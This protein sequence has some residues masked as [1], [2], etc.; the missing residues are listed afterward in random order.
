VKEIRGFHECTSLS[1][2]K[3]PSAFQSLSYSCFSKCVL[4]HVIGISE[5]IVSEAGYFALQVNLM[6]SQVWITWVAG[7]QAVVAS[8]SAIY[9]ARSA[10]GLSMQAVPTTA[11]RDRAPTAITGARG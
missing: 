5:L 2:I 6:P 8:R 11:T 10:S 1:R 4:P 7:W 9:G 3:I